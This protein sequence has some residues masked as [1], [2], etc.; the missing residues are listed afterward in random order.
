MKVQVRQPQVGPKRGKQSVQADQPKGD[1]QHIA[2]TVEPTKVNDSQQCADYTK[3]AYIRTANN[4]NP[5]WYNHGSY[6]LVES[7]LVEIE[8]LPRDLRVPDHCC[9]RADVPDHFARGEI[10]WQ[11]RGPGKPKCDSAAHPE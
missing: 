11:Y 3:R 10:H 4:V 9:S 7:K 8:A 1:C 6:H 5:S 2:K